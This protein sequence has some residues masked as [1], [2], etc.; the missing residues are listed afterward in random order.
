M[1]LV[2]EAL[3]KQG[4][5]RAS[6]NIILS[7][8]RQSTKR[9]YT[10]Y[11]QQ[12]L[13]YCSE[14]SKDP[15]NPTPVELITF[16]TK[17]FKTG[18]GYSALNIAR[19]AVATLS[20]TNPVTV[21]NHPLVK[22]FL[23]G[24][25]NRRPSLPKHGLTWDANVVLQFLRAWSPAKCLSLR[26]LTLKVLL[27]C[28]LVTGQRGQAMWLMDLRNMSWTR[29]EV[30]CRFGDLLKT[31]SPAHHQSE[32]VFGAFPDDKSLCVVR[33]LTQYKKRTRDLRGSET[34]L[35]V[36]WKTP[37][38]AVSRDTIRRWTKLVLQ[39][40]GI[41]MTIFTPHSTRAA[42]SSKAAQHVPLKTILKTVG[43]RRQSTFATFYQKSVMDSRAFG[44]A[45]LSQ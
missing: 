29:H 9:T 18:I 25:F 6:A 15:F 32:I 34:R 3:E 17:L 40:A 4:L 30:R 41:D 26:Q 33:Y 24:V 44:E 16:L 21:G 2:R 31:S 12:W 35:F 19:S 23:K 28:L 39:K 36:S 45:V 42:S 11:I 8:W 38:K 1:C 7:A 10:T 22:K 13:R 20:L 27:L 43:W 5:P 14:Q 37:H